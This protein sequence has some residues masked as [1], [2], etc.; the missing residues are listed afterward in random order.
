MNDSTGGI[1]HGGGWYKGMGIQPIDYAE[2]NKLGATQFS[3]VKY[4][5]RCL[6]VPKEKGWTDLKKAFHFLQMIARRYFAKEVQ[7]VFPED[8]EVVSDTVHKVGETECRV[9]V[10]RGTGPVQASPERKP[11]KLFLDI[12]A[13]VAQLR[14]VGNDRATWDSRRRLVAETDKELPR[15][16]KHY[17]G[18]VY[19]IQALM[20][21]A[22]DEEKLVVA[23]NSVTEADG[24]CPCVRDAA[25]FFGQLEDGRSR[26]EPHEPPKPEPER[27]DSMRAFADLGIRASKNP[28]GVY[29]FTHEKT[30]ETVISAGLVD[31]PSRINGFALVEPRQESEGSRFSTEQV[32][33]KLLRGGFLTD[34]QYKFLTKETG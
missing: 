12:A 23:Y 1:Q 14:T 3:V 9:V 16:W 30:G 18:G 28:S 2:E 5:S 21:T 31:D 17:K 33:D 27:T 20:L 7:V 29:F 11:V 4:V 24:C 32:A 26:F 8:F 15:V 6:A 19:K 10:S 34:E 13:L 22:D 25:D